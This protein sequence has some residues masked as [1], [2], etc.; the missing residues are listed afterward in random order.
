MS[1][2]VN[3]A[4]HDKSMCSHHLTSA[5]YKVS[6]HHPHH[7]WQWE[8]AMVTRWHHQL[9][10]T[11]AYHNMIVCPKFQANHCTNLHP[12][13]LSH[14]R[15]RPKKEFMKPKQLWQSL[16]QWRYCMWQRQQREEKSKG[17]NPQQT[18]IE[19]QSMQHPRETKEAEQAR[20]CNIQTLST[21]SNLQSSVQIHVIS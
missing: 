12:K 19:K 17:M 11:S 3:K 14:S 9:P 6:D 15:S 5:T 18:N 7:E 8:A 16:K 4:R 1:V 13:F 20:S 2:P 10:T 21:R